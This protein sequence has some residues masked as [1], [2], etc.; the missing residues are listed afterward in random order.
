MQHTFLTEILKKR[1]H[2]GHNNKLYFQLKD[3]YHG[4]VVKFIMKG[5]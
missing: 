5:K 3:K 4:D 2:K 1:M